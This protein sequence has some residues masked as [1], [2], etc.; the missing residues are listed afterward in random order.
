MM[1]VQQRSDGRARVAFVSRT[2]SKVYRA[3][4]LAYPGRTDGSCSKT[5]VA[6]TEPGSIV[7]E[8][9]ESSFDRQPIITWSSVSLV[10][11]CR[12]ES[13]PE[14]QGGQH[15]RPRQR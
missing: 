13:C 15:S 1:R 11:R 10:H 8:S 2:K 7:S 3:R 5:L 14:G 9:S 4:M 12:F 6:Q